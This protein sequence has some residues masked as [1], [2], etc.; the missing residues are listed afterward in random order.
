MSK[1]INVLSPREVCTALN[2]SQPTLWRLR[3]AGRFPAP[4]HVSDRRI[5]WPED[6]LR[7]WLESRRAGKAA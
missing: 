2:I 7:D 6:T 4:V 1:A 3:Q 5:G